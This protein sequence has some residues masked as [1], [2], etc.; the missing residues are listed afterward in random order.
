MKIALRNDRSQGLRIFIRLYYL[1][2]SERLSDNIK[3]TFHKALIRSVMTYA[4]PAWEF[5]ADTYLMKLQ[6]LQNKILRTTDNF[7]RRTPV[8]DLHM[9]PNLPYVYDYI[10]ELCRQ[11]A[12]VIQNHEN[13]YVRSIA[14]GEV[15]HIKK[16]GLNL[17]A[18]SLTTVQV[19]KLP[20]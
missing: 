9:A 3:L 7:P 12:E 17:A 18:V 16:R 8:H 20:L 11:Q 10:T 13:K 19:T 14:Q 4:Y 15:R 6:R 2:K 5:S 1:L